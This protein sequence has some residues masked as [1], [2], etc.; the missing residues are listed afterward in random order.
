MRAQR[1][2]EAAMLLSACQQAAQRDADR[3]RQRRRAVRTL[4]GVV[5]AAALLVGCIA[6]VDVLALNG[7]GGQDAMTLQVTTGYGAQDADDEAIAMESQFGWNSIGY[8]W[9]SLKSS[10]WCMFSQDKDKC[11]NN[12]NCYKNREK[13]ASAD[14]GSGSGSGDFNATV[15]DSSEDVDVGAGDEAEAPA[16]STDNPTQPLD[17]GGDGSDEEAPADD[18]DEAP[19]DEEA[20]DDEVADEEVADDE[21]PA[22]DEEPADGETV[23]EDKD[24]DEDMGGED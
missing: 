10:T 16:T 20:P 11:K 13:A 6:A 21:A 15:G 5:G 24:E 9:C 2:E 3:M 22:G 8:G 17:L 14:D 1:A 18:E 19:E 7:G 12:I 4:F 23:T